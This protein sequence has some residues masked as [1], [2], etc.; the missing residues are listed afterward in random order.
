MSTSNQE[1]A[2]A[3]VTMQLEDK[4]VVKAIEPGLLAAL[5]HFDMCLM[6][7]HINLKEKC[8]VLESLNVLIGILGFNI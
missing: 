3:L 7:S 4:R 8:Q 5:I 6:R 2:A 1:E